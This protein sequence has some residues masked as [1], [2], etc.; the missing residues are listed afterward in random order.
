MKLLG[1]STDDL[2]NPPMARAFITRLTTLL[3]GIGI[4]VI[5]G[6]WLGN[7]QTFYLT[8]SVG[9][10]VVVLVAFGMQRKAWILIPLTYL[11][12]GVLGKLPLRLTPRDLGVLLAATS[13]VAYRVLSHENMRPKL[14]LLDL[15]VGLNV[16]YL[17]FNLVKNPIG[18]LIFGSQSIGG[19][20]V[21]NICIALLAY[22]VIIRLPNNV[23]SVSRIPYYVLVSAT[24]VSGL[25]LL[26]Y[27][28]PSL[29]SAVSSW[30][31]GVETHEYLAVLAGQPGIQRLKGLATFGFQLSLVLCAYYP[32]A[33]LFDPRRP[34]FYAMLLGTV[35][36][37]A[38][39]FRNFM[40]WEMAALAIGGWLQ[41]RWRELVKAGFF[42][43]MLLA[44]LVLGQG[45]VYRL[46][47]TVQRS[48]A[49]LPGQWSPTVVAETEES[50][51]SRFQL[52]KEVIEWGQIKDWWLGDGFGANLEDAI[53]TYRGGHGSYKDWVILSGSFHSGP[54]TTIRYVG[55]C[56]LV[57]LYLLTISAAFYSYRCV[58]E[59]RGT[60][61]FP[62][63]IYFAIQLIWGPVHYTFVFGGYDGFMP[64][65]LFYVGC[66]RLLFRMSDELKQNA[67]AET[68]P[69]PAQSLV[70]A[71]A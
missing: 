40:L 53:A 15:L 71:P 25:N 60:P 47:E 13:Y 8:C 55:I 39:G 51:T 18:F 4:A 49:F 42:G 16:I 2:Q 38:S 28:V 54:L 30:Y 6:Y 45:R 68:R 23:T 29:T 65:L 19:R 20:P 66:L 9:V 52:W 10:L 32:P 63:A 14:H 48:L 41:Q 5:I 64:E 36:I 62:V 7:G 43:A 57:F 17:A 12:T 27:I 24:V 33:T 44:L 22:W 67:V 37:L 59:C 46:P 58:N 3:V 61:L 1:I 31:S 21:V 11:M 70:S 56:G 50:T 34:R 26:L 69:A 35:C